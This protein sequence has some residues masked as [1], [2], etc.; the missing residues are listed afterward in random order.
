MQAIGHMTTELISYGD[1][2]E[3]RLLIDGRIARTMIEKKSFVERAFNTIDDDSDSALHPGIL[4]HETA[5]HFLVGGDTHS[6]NTLQYSFEL[7][8]QVM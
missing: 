4:E 7:D 2:Y 6:D 3:I 5:M 8:Q 1:T